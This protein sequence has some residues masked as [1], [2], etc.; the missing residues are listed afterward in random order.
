MRTPVAGAS[1]LLLAALALLAPLASPIPG[2]PEATATAAISEAPEPWQAVLQSVETEA[3][4]LDPTWAKPLA[5]RPGDSI[6][7][8]LS[9][10]VEVATAYVVNVET[11]SRVDLT[12]ESV[13]KMADSV[14]IKDGY[15][16]GAALARL[17]LPSDAAPGLYNLYLVLSD[18]DI[19]WMPHSLIVYDAPPEELVI[20]HLTDTQLGAIDK[21]ILNDLKLARYV[22]LINT[23]KYEL[24]LNLVVVT[25]D[26]SD[27]GINVSSY[28]NWVFAMN[29]LL[30]P[31]FTAPG[32]HDWAQVPGLKAFLLDFYGKYNVPARYWAAKW[33]NFLFIGLDSQSEGYVEPE[34]LDFLENVLSQ[35]SG[36]NVVAM[37]MFHHPI[38]SDPGRYKGDPESFRGALYG[39]WESHFDLV[40]R[41]F[42]I[43]NKYEI[44]KVVF[45][46]H[47]HRD[48]DAIYFRQ[49]NTAVYFITTTTSMHGHPQG[50]FWGAKV[51][52]V[53]ADGQVEVIS[54]DREY[55]LEKG[56]IDTTGFEVYS[57]YGTG[58]KS[59]SWIYNIEDFGVALERLTLVYP[60]S[61]AV[62]AEVYKNN[63]I[64]EGLTPVDIRIVD[65]G[66]YYLGIG[67]FEIDSSI[68]KTVMYGEP[69][70]TPPQIEVQSVVPSKPFPGSIVTIQVKVSDVGWG[71]ERIYAEVLGTGDEVPVFSGLDPSIYVIRTQAVPGME[72]IKVTA[73]DIAGNT[74]EAVIE[75]EV[76]AP[77]TTTTTQPPETTETTETE[78]AKETVP[79]T[80]TMEETVETTTTGEKTSVTTTTVETGEKT[81]TATTVETGQTVGGGFDS[82]LIILGAAVAAAIIIL[83]AAVYRSRA[84]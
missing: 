70:E 64:A 29:Q 38:F 12:V 78:T 77:Q 69:D 48:A 7:V 40:E 52:R 18:G 73:V 42:D 34:G 60:L 47:V 25:G 81:A 74:S 80:T 19:I 65:Q 5:A 54:L 51:V 76:P 68:G 37:I 84:G 9:T 61:K 55:R 62:P 20:L 63:L 26:I 67:T 3:R 66:L 28:R 2:A 50:Y 71:I 24:G 45:A 15:V 32:N 33:G 44:V 43:I 27:I 14:S 72:G 58:G 39:S 1:L 82:S 16:V 4:I 35:Y 8:E 46:G 53:T 36:E 41:F 23:L 11:G 30:V 21:G 13:E 17:S 59:Y 31:A 56:S 49:D 57:S 75:L 79:E 83:A 22:A 6:E 10:Y